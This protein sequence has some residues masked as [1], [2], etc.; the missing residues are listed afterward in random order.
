MAEFR[1]TDRLGS[2]AHIYVFPHARGVDVCG[3]APAAP[4]GRG[5]GTELAG[6]HA[7]AGGCLS[8]RLSPKTTIVQ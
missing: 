4:Q 5:M 7:H 8:L 3:K 6:K 1:L 2:V